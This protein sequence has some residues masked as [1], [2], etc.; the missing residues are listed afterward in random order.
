MITSLQG[1]IAM[2][3]E[4]DVDG[5]QESVVQETE[6]TQDEESAQSG[7][8]EEAAPAEEENKDEIAAEDS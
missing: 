1:G 2:A 4:T 6:L 5:A 8:T 3:A 7:Q